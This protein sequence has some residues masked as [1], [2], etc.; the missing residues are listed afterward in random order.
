[1]RS[2]IGLHGWRLCVGDGGQ[3]RLQLNQIKTEVLWCSLACLPLPV[4][5]VR[6]GNA[7][8]TPVP[9]VRD[10]VIYVEADVTTSPES[11]QFSE[12]SSPSAFSS[13]RASFPVAQLTL[14][15]LIGYCRQRG[16]L[17]RH[18]ACR[19]Q[20]P[21]PRSFSVSIEP[22]RLLDP[23]SKKTRTLH[24]SEPIACCESQTISSFNYVFWRCVVC[25]GTLGLTKPTVFISVDVDVLY[26]CLAVYMD[27]L[28][29][30]IKH[31]FSATV[32]SLWRWFGLDVVYQ[33][34]VKLLTVLE[35]S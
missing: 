1:M 8:V 22:L 33:L 13:L 9:S 17:L 31:S 10:L 28:A 27:L 15:T 4:G 7:D 16:G 5:T 18:N 12:A 29:P 34:P 3:Y 25:P 14:L 20:P 11:K 19:H 26:L 6:V 35:Y 24:R 23:T 32:P 21:S 30:S 2:V